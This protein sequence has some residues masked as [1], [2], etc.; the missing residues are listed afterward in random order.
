[1]QPMRIIFFENNPA[2]FLSHRLGLAQALRAEGHDVHVLAMPGQAV[3]TIRAAGFVFHPVPLKRSGLNPFSELLTLARICSLYRKLRPELV[4]QI[5][6]KPVI[7]GT[8]AARIVNVRSVMSVIS[9]LGYFALQEGVGGGLFRRFIFLLYR[10]ALRHPN[11]RIVFHNGA[12]RDLFVARHIVAMQQTTVVPGS[13]VDMSYYTPS[14]E[15]SGIPVVVLPARMLRDKGVFEFVDAATKLRNAGLSARFLLVGGADPGNPSAI[16]ETQLQQWNVEGNVEWQ[17]HAADMRAV[18]AG[19]HVVCQPSYREGLARVL[20]EA[21]ACG[22]AVVSTDV[23]GCRDA[24]VAGE[25]GLLVPPRDS[26]RLA[27]ALRKL[28]E[29]A[30]LRKKFGHDA[31]QHALKHFAVERIVELT[32]ASIHQLVRK[33]D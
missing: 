16:P 30:A 28:I 4:Y 33:P 23:P 6:V 21:A 10:I 22:R 11:Q 14:E 2:Y 24:V 3:A 26:T 25:T 18:Y 27:Q 13:G 15:P 20:I 1:M 12:D 19:C 32:M 17:G 31:R 7:Y 9:G 5:T 29:D 8:L